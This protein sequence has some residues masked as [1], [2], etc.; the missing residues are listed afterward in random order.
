MENLAR[1]SSDRVERSTA[2]SLA[3]A[4]DYLHAPISWGRAST[5]TAHGALDSGGAWGTRVRSMHIW[6]A[7][8]A[9]P[10]TSPN[11]EK[12]SERVGK[13]LNHF[14]FLHLNT[15]IKTKM[16]K[17]D[18]NGISRILKT[19]QFERNYVEHGRYTKIQY[20]IPIHNT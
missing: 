15:K 17:S 5:Y 10:A 8:C 14:L 12:G 16:I 11:D 18:T 9:C 1:P 20:E 19:D 13:L 6:L 3:V 7:I 2:R 4:V